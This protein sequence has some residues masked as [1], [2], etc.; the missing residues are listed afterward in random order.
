METQT[1]NQVQA[2]VAVSE[3]SA[4]STLLEKEF[5]PKSDRSKEAVENA[6]Q[7]LAEQALQYTNLISSDVC[8]SIEAMIAEIDKS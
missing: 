7:T 3:G 4:F 2:D 8:D 5:K 1:E 6:V